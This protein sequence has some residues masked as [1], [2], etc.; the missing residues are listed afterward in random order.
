MKLAKSVEEY[1]QSLKDK[2][3]MSVSIDKNLANKLMNFEYR[4]SKNYLN[5]ISIK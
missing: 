4:K 2:S 3:D 1:K 5:K